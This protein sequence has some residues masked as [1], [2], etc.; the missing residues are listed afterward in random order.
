MEDNLNDYLAF[1]SGQ[2]TVV[3]E[4]AIEDTPLEEEVINEET[5]PEE[6]IT[7]EV[8]TE[9]VDENVEQTTEDV[10]EVTTPTKKKVTVDL[11]T[12]LEE[13][14]EVLKRYLNDLDTDYSK[15]SDKDAVKLKLKN[16]NPSWS[17]ADV[18]AELNDKYAFD[19]LDKDEDLLTEEDEKLI[20]RGARLLKSDAQKAKQ[21]LEDIKATFDSLPELSLEIDEPV[22]ETIIEE[23]FSQ[24]DYIKQVTEQN[25]KQKE[26]VWIPTLQN[27]LNEIETL[28]E[29]IPYEDGDY[30]GEINVSYKLSD[31]EKQ[32][33]L[34][35]LSDYIAN[36]SDD[37]YFNADGSVNYKG[38]V[39]DKAKELNFHKI[40][41]TAVKEARATAREDFIEKDLKNFSEEVRNIVPVETEISELDFFRKKS[42]KKI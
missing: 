1:K 9:K 8:V 32:E 2:S 21:S 15:L 36:P 28:T 37:K 10:V 7:T 34:N 35:H 16:D 6:V 14:I 11:N 23:S 42:G 5:T 30:K 38:F 22:A 17:D 12:Y 18:E 19:L 26:E 3:E 13:N 20:K 41:K 33:V 39:E 29:K 27:T 25:Q 40:L 31:V 4:T 24:E